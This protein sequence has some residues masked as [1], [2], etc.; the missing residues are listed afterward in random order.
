MTDEASVFVVYPQKDFSQ[1][2]GV[3]DGIVVESTDIQ[4]LNMTVRSA[5]GFDRAGIILFAHPKYGGNG[6]LFSQTEK[7]ITKEFPPD[8]W[9]GVNS[10][11]VYEGVWSLFLGPDLQ[12]AKV[13]IDGRDQFGPGTKVENLSPYAADQVR[14]IQNVS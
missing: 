5:Q 2:T 4:D 10:F 14:S 9:D 11:L 13:T 6:Q 12:G 1:A 8:T 3:P 7:N